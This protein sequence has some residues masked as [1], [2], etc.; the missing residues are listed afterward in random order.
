MQT[1]Q[2]VQ[3]ARL[4]MGHHGLL[5][6]GW[7]FKLNSNKTRLGVCKYRYNRIEMSLL[8]VERVE[9]EIIFNTIKHEIAHALVG[10]G[11]GH[12]WTWKAKAIE[13]GAKPKACTVVNV[14][15]PSKYLGECQ[16][17][18]KQ[19]AFHRKLKHSHYCVKCGPLNG[20]IVVSKVD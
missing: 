13:V 17:C 6:K 15:I 16:T 10:R 5:D 4:L 7:T 3:E 19:F 9:D 14:V 18:K 1:S 8:Y 2:V 12:N 11:H 20:K